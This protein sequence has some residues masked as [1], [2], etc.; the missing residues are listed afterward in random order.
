MRSL[1]QW[2]AYQE[3]QHPQAI[4][5]GLER[6]SAVW[7]RMNCPGFRCVVTIAGTNGK[8]TAA[9]ALDALAR[10]SNW[11]TGRYTSPHLYRYNERITLDGVPVSDARLCAA[12]E[13]IEQARGSTTLTYFEYGTLAALAIFAQEDLDLV[14][15][16]VGLGGR[17][18]A[19]N[20]IDAD[21]AI[22]CSIAL[23]HQDWLGSDLKKIAAEKAAVARAGK[24]AI[25]ADPESNALYRPALEKIGARMIECAEPDSADYSRGLPPLSLAAAKQAWALIAGRQLDGQEVAVFAGLC[26]PG[27]MQRMP[28][29]MGEYLLDVAHNP[30][31]ATRLAA[32]VRSLP[33]M[34]TALVIGMQGDKD[35]EHSCQALAGIAERVFTCDLPAPRGA[36]G[37]SLA[38]FFRPDLAR[39]LA[40][41][42]EALAAAE[43]WA[44]QSGRSTR[45]II[46]GS[47]VTVGECG[48]G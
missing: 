14:I 1:A 33:K 16:E 21:V 28:A 47:F 39:A 22:L 38:G 31:A 19:T 6:V 25:V 30:A 24:P 34:P 18:D 42:R 8:G 44:K 15:L 10:D 5:L 29:E 3:G 2:L 41:P 12:F 36:S 17:L 35:I 32:C 26:V 43:N 48:L 23:D 27:R 13:Q 45:I 4:D 20:I 7:A 46:A 40:S 9:H 11:R 37:A